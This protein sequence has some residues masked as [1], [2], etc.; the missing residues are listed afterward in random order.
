MTKTNLVM[1]MTAILLTGVVG[2][3]SGFMPSADAAKGSG[4]YLPVRIRLL[5][6]V[7]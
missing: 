5:E 3:S 7:D 6:Y 1:V 2:L 4:V